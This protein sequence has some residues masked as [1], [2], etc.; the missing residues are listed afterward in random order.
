MMVMPVIMIVTVVVT[1]RMMMVVV[2]M[3]VIAIRPADMVVMVMIEEMRIVFQRALEIEGALIEHAG[4]IDAGAAG[5]V[6][7]GRRVDGADDILDLRQFF[8]RHE[9][10]LV[11][12]HDVGK[13][14]LVFGL[15][16]V[17]EAQRQVLGVDE[18]DHGVELGLGAHVV[19]HEEGLGD[20]HR[21]GKARGLDDDAVEAAGAAHQAFDDADQ[22]A[23][24]RAA[25][26][27][28]VHLVDLFVGLDDE[29]VVDADLAELVDDDRIFLAVVLRQD[30]VEQGRLAGAEIAGENGN[31]NWLLAAWR[32]RR[33]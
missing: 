21:I 28:V 10:G 6:D 14:D 30:A 12:Q 1:V 4:E 9:V 19:V 5:L 8:R 24:H 23:A 3:I 11:D 22:V 15:A 7:A 31:G 20:R 17:L 29:V 16:A 25:D 13:G 18:G 27:A 26:A 2:A 33:S 32:L